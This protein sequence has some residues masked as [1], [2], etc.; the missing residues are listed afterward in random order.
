[1][2]MRLILVTELVSQLRMSW[3]NEALELNKLDISV[4][5]VVHDAAS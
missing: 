4:T 5:P 3:L 1:M 2:N